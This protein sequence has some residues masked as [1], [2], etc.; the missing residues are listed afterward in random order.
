MRESDRDYARGYALV[1]RGDG[2]PDAVVQR[3]ARL[4]PETERRSLFGSREID[5]DR[6]RV[7]GGVWRPPDRDTPPTPVRPS[8]GPE[9]LSGSAS[10]GGGGSGGGGSSASGG[11]SADRQRQVA[12]RLSDRELGDQL[13]AAQ[14]WERWYRNPDA[15]RWRWDRRVLY[16]GRA[17]RD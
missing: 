13:K 11:T 17:L 4:A 12:A 3:A 5:L 8:P 14:R 9:V 1:T 7:K 15:W 6:W 10:G 2:V 16:I